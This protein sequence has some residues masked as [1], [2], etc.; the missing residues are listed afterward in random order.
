M[1][2]ARIDIS[3]SFNDFQNRWEPQ[4]E[5]KPR[6]AWGEARNQVTSAA[7]CI[8]TSLALALVLAYLCPDCLR[9]WEQWHSV[10]SELTRLAR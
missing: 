1:V 8:S 5:Q 9:H 7:P 4:V 3:S 2:A 10:T 6:S